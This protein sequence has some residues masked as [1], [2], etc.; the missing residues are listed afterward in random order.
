M[1]GMKGRD[2]KTRNTGAA[3]PPLARP[4]KPTPIDH[5]LLADEVHLSQVKFQPY[6]G[7]TEEK[8]PSAEE[9]AALDESLRQWVE[10]H[11]SRGVVVT[12]TVH[13]LGAGLQI[14]LIG[15]HYNSRTVNA[16]IWPILVKTRKLFEDDESKKPGHTGKLIT[17]WVKPGYTGPYAGDFGKSNK[18]AHTGEHGGT[19]GDEANIESE[20]ITLFRKLPKGER[21]TVINLLRDLAGGEVTGRAKEPPRPAQSDDAATVRALAGLEHLRK[22]TDLALSSPALPE[23]ERARQSRQL[24][25]AFERLQGRGVKMDTP[26]E[27]KAARRFLT[28]YNQRQKELKAASPS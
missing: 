22:Q 24:V 5:P 11:R 12:Y 27:V 20:L 28:P 4:L 14:M 26:P 1:V 10:D 7:R 18:P 13:N 16:K 2:I 15:D 21:V 17:D 23:A 25:R 9:I 19:V 3:L 8:F 6:L